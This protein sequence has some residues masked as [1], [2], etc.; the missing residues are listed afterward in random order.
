[1][2]AHASTCPRC[3]SDQIIHDA[4]VEDRSQH[5]RHKL[6]VLVGFNDPDAL[7]FTDPIR[8]ELRAT[9]CGQCG[10]VG[11]FV[12]EPELLWEAYTQAPSQVPPE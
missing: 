4:K 12:R 2:D 3:S 10:H 5:G 8:A 9:I 11:L 1:M 6:E 7:L